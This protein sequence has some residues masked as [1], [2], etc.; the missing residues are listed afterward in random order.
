MILSIFLF[1]I[2]SDKDRMRR[3]NT[4][5]NYYYNNISKLPNNDVSCI[6][7]L[8]FLSRRTPTAPFCFY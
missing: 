5:Y 4:P 2:V 3:T 8:M 7:Y 6:T 1:L